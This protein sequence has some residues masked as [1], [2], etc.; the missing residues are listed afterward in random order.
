MNKHSI[1]TTVLIN[2]DQEI[3]KLMESGHS[4]HTDIML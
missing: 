4:F 1:K 3:N 2:T